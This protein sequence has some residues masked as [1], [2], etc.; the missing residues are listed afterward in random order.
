MMPESLGW[1]RSRP[2]KGRGSRSQVTT[3]AGKAHR[4]RDDVYDDQTPKR[5]VRPPWFAARWSRHIGMKCD[6]RCG[7]LEIL[8]CTLRRRNRC[9]AAECPE[10]VLHGA[11]LWVKR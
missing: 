6:E 9:V 10:C 4:A 1:S 8:S 11:A 7:D 3:R 2:V 5:A